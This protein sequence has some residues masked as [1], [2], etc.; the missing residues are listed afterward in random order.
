MVL[1]IQWSNLEPF[2]IRHGTP[3]TWQYLHS[4]STLLLLSPYIG[5]SYYVLFAYVNVT[6]SVHTEYVAE[7]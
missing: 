3:D 7:I 6:N 4:L 1:K 2:I 5:Q